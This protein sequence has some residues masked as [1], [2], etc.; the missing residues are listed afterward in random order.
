MGQLVKSKSEFNF[1]EFQVETSKSE[2]DSLAVS[3]VNTSAIMGKKKSKSPVG[4][5]KSMVKAA[6]VATNG[7]ITAKHKAKA[8][9]DSCDSGSADAVL[10][11]ENKIK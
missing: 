6:A 2:F 3:V 8:K 4:K 10:L 5:K 9:T 11:L 1:E 7:T